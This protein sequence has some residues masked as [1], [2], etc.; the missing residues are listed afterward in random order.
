VAIPLAGTDIDYADYQ[1]RLVIDT[2]ILASLKTVA[3][4]KA[5]SGVLLSIFLG[6]L[7]A[8]AKGFERAAQLGV[9]F[10]RGGRRIHLGARTP[11]RDVGI[12]RLFLLGKGTF[13]V[14]VIAIAL[15]HVS[16]PGDSGSVHHVVA[17]YRGIEATSRRVVH[18]CYILAIFSGFALH[19]VDVK[20]LVRPQVRTAHAR[21]R[22]E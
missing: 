11:S 16:L 15:V 1:R 7:V 5:G 9:T 2:G 18:R 4:S 19:A 17:A 10:P 20:N 13:S 14:S 3:M 21:G 12:S 6:D 22:V 8:L